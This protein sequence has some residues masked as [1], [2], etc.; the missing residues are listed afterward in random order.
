[1]TSRHRIRRE[2]DVSRRTLGVTGRLKSQVPQLLPNQELRKLE[3]KT[4]DDHPGGELVASHLVPRVRARICVSLRPHDEP[5]HVEPKRPPIA[6]R[7]VLSSRVTRHIT[8]VSPRSRI[9]R[10]FSILIRSDSTVEPPLPRLSRA[11]PPSHAPTPAPSPRVF[12]APLT[13]PYSAS[14]APRSRARTSPP[15]PRSTPCPAIRAFRGARIP[16]ARATALSPPPR[17]YRTSPGTFS[18]TETP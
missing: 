10:A 1:M 17:D 11:S 7:R 14:R 12:V 16:F 18:R 5:D 3:H 2:I 9:I 13:K 4:Q 15:P 6:H 8:I